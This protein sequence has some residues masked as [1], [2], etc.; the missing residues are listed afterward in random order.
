MV[1]DVHDDDLDDNLE[2]DNEYDRSEMGVDDKITHRNRS[3]Q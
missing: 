1:E 3:R 2:K